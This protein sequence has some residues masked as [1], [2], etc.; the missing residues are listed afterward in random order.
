MTVSLTKQHEV[1]VGK[2]NSKQ[3]LIFKSVMEASL[4][5]KQEL[6]FVYGHGGTGKTFLWTTIIFALRC[7]G[8]IVLAVASSG[9][10]SL[11]LPSGR[12]AHSRFKIPL[13]LTDDS[14]CHV[15]KN[16]QLSKLLLETALI[17]WDESPMN[18]RRCFEA[19]DKTLRDILDQPTCPFGG[20][21]VLLGGDFRQ[22][23]PVKSKGTKM[24]IIASSI[25]ESSIWRHFK[26]CKLTENMRLLQP[27]LSSAE[28]EGI[29]AFSS[30]L[31]QVG[32][33]QIG[34]DDEDDPIDTKWVEIP[35]KYVIHD[36]D[37]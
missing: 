34:L 33:G 17:I 18:D 11:L 15:K 24:D 30:W 10:A 20:K 26:I 1:L 6:I 25:A 2:L 32:D 14:I 35:E 19:L 7:T 36:H 37:S 16:T 28:K 4:G 12:T 5:N 3:K 23:L 27:N 13:D 21:S 31:L 9:I 29:A 22:T 8:K